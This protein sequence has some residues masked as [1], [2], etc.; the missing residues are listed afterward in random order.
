MYVRREVDS[1]SL[2]Y[3]PPPHLTGIQIKSILL[4]FEGFYGGGGPGQIGSKI[5]R[6]RSGSA[7]TRPGGKGQAQGSS[8]Q[9]IHS[10]K[11]KEEEDDEDNEAEV[12][13]VLKDDMK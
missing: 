5:S 2:R 8:A 6:S 13:C 10:G 3:T 9:P 12:S 4:Y 1:T 11:S 7:V